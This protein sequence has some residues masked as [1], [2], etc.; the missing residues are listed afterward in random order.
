MA[1]AA[2]ELCVRSVIVEQSYQLADSN[3]QQFKTA[4]TAFDPKATQFIPTSQLLP[5]LKTVQYPMGLL[6]ARTLC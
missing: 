3:I 4:W 2:T 5:L 1:T 6:N